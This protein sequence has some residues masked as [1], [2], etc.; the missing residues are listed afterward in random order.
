MFCK[1]CGKEV[2]ENAAFCPYCGT[3]VSKPQEVASQEVAPKEDNV[4][5][6]DTPTNEAV[7]T[8][9]K[10]KNKNKK[11]NL[12]ALIGLV[13]SICVWVMFWPIN[14]RVYVCTSIACVSLA[15]SIVGYIFAEKK[16]YNFKRLAIAGLVISIVAIIF[17]PL[18][19]LY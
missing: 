18:T 8:D 3:T 17:W 12:Y 7:N 6:T 9:N 4:P 13:L 2:N 10:P 5:V 16:D 1:K 19:L 11:T 15:L 14:Y